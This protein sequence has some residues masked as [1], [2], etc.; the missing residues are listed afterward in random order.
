[1]TIKMLG[2]HMQGLQFPSEYSIYL[3]LWVI[4]SNSSLTS[5]CVHFATSY[6]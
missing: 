1:M 6:L 2:G 4:S 3:I 5:V